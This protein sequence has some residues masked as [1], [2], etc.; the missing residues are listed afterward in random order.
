MQA[1][2]AQL[3]KSGRILI[4]APVRRKLGLREGSL[5]IVKVNEKGGLDVESRSQ[6]L[7]RVQ[8]KLRKYIP[9]GVPVSDQ[10][11]A[12]RRAEAAR[13]NRKPRAGAKK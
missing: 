6:A 1:F 9:E 12:D 5:V 10:L 11:I 8:S 2:T 3:E 7:A 13:E 4:P